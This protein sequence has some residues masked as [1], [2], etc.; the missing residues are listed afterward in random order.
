MIHRLFFDSSCKVHLCLGEI[1]LQEHENTESE[2]NICISR[3][4][5]VGCLKCALD[6][7]KVEVST[8]CARDFLVVWVI[9]EILK[10]VVKG[11][12]F[13]QFVGEANTESKQAV[14]IVRILIM[15]LFECD[16]S[17]VILI[18]LLIELTKKLPCLSILHILLHFG[19]KAEHSLL[20][21]TLLNELTCSS[22][23]ISRLLTFLHERI[24]LGELNFGRVALHFKLMI[25]VPDLSPRVHHFVHV[26]H[27]AS[28]LHPLGH[29]FVHI[30]VFK[31]LATF[32]D[33]AEH[34]VVRFY[35][36]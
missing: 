24:L 9:F 12:F 11:I 20:H 28:F 18:R 29:H 8:L 21:L 5:L 14:Q 34:L 32:E 3:V 27:R 6:L 16:N 31:L 17:L 4:L 26:L 33:V 36:T 25:F 10:H 7:D 15:R 23:Q 2:K 35:I 19:L 1:T 30:V 22:K 13:N